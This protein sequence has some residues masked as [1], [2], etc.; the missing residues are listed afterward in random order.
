MYVIYSSDNT[1]E[2]W[3]S[4][5]SIFLNSWFFK[6]QETFHLILLQSGTIILTPIFCLVDDKGNW[7]STKV[8]KINFKLD[9][10]WHVTHNVDMQEHFTAVVCNLIK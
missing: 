7:K 5:N 9:I 1:V 8:K 2:S 3:F 10:I 4:K 6:N